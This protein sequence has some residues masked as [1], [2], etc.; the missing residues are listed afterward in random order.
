MSSLTRCGSLYKV[1]VAYLR[2]GFMFDIATRH[3]AKCCIP[4][5]IAD[6]PFGCSAAFMK[7]PL[8]AT[9]TSETLSLATYAENHS[10]EPRDGES[11]A[12]FISRIRPVGT[13]VVKGCPAWQDRNHSWTWRIDDW[14]IAVLAT[15]NNDYLV[16][17]EQGANP[18]CWYELMVFG[19]TR[20][21]VCHDDPWEFAVDEPPTISRCRVKNRSHRTNCPRQE[22]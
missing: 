17:W 19:G 11:L 20:K 4:N 3:C 16:S 6:K 15:T 7:G 12:D 22:D 14:K 2:F 13:P 5:R 10:H 1:F 21:L 18:G 9:A 8:M